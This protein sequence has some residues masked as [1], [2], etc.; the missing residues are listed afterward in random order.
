M[1]NAVTN[2]ELRIDA[3]AMKVQNA[4][5]AA[6]AALAALA[7]AIEEMDGLSREVA[8]CLDDDLEAADQ[9][10]DTDKVDQLE[11]ALSGVQAHYDASNT[12]LWADDVKGMVDTINGK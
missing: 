2:M 10:A 3:A 12:S 11:A 8:T 1:N 4:K 5:V 6:K 7:A 9:D